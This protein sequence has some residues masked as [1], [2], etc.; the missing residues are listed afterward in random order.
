MDE[1]S[2][3]RQGQ[4]WPRLAATVAYTLPWAFGIW[5]GPRW[6][7]SICVAWFVFYFSKT[8]WSIRPG[9]CV[10]CGRRTL[11]NI[12]RIGQPLPPAVAWYNPWPENPRRW[13]AIYGCER[14]INR[15]IEEELYGR[16]R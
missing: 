2:S 12:P 15:I 9:R 8:A 7:N 10:D 4:Q 6:L 11:L 14:H 3:I 1:S 13:N 5:L 16:R